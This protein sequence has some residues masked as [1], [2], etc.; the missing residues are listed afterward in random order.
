MMGKFMLAIFMLEIALISAF[1]IQE[2]K[3]LAARRWETLEKKDEN[4][5][6]TQMPI[7]LGIV[8]DS[9]SSISN[10]DFRI[11]KKFL[12]DFLEQY[13][14]GTGKNDVRV[15][16]ITYG[17][18]I[19]PQDGFNLTSYA[20]KEQVL[21]AIDKIPHRQGLFTD[22]GKAIKYM[23]VVQLNNSVVRPEAEKVSIVITD[24]NAQVKKETDSEAKSARNDGINIFAVGVGHD[25]HDEELN[26]IAGDHA[27]VTRV[28]N[29]SKL[30]SIKESLARKTCIKKEKPANPPM[31]K[32]PACGEVNPADIYF[33][34]DPAQLGLDAIAWTT[35]LISQTM[36]NMDMKNGFQYGV[37]SGTCPDDA[38]FDLDDYNNVDDIKK[39]LQAYDRSKVKDLLQYLGTKAYTAEHGGREN[40][41][42][43]AVLSLGKD[44]KSLGDLKSQITELNNQGIQVFIADYYNQN[45][46]LK[47]T[48]TLVG[49]GSSL[50][51]QDLIRRLCPNI[52][53]K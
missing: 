45:I 40:S 46:Q 3:S 11:A 1:S 43:V 33:V 13:D 4:L 23:H 38:G 19:Y 32:I 17:K 31:V 29:F 49:Q 44:I 24:G 39:R 16:I 50:V 47:G 27:R 28:D 8:L 5:I 21:A 51:S 22:T 12:N 7:E 15:S 37:I 53:S 14:I 42:K 6:C 48:T 26:I 18:G 30:E 36:D 41:K 35:T 20:T 10:K 34:F 2:L 52:N 25:I 9:S